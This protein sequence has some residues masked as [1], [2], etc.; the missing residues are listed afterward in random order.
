MEL[1]KLIPNVTMRQ[2]LLPSYYLQSTP[3][4]VD[5]RHYFVQSTLHYATLHYSGHYYNNSKGKKCT[6]EQTC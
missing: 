6:R 3:C 5:I 1:E 2:F 4:N